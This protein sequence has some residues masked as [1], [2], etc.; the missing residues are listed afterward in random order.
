MKIYKTTSFGKDGRQTKTLLSAI[1]LNT[2][3][4][5]YLEEK[6]LISEV[7]SLCGIKNGSTKHKVSVEVDDTNNRFNRPSLHMAVYYVNAETNEPDVYVVSMASVLESKRYAA[8]QKI[9]TL[10]KD[11]KRG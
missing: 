8:A 4:T 9:L 11:Y 6:E 10:L 2:E 7:Y 5:V 1:P 3:Y